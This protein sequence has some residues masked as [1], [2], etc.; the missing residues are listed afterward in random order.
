MKRESVNPWDWGLAFNMDQGELVEGATRILHCSGQVSVEPDAEAEMG[1]AVVSPGNIRG[2]IECALDII[3]FHRR[4]EFPGENIPRV[5]VHHRREI[6]PAP[7]DNVDVRKIRL[8]EL[9]NCAGRMTE[10]ICS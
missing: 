9:M 10:R 3:C 4:T 8:P 5:I 7:A 2:Q 6:V 1:L